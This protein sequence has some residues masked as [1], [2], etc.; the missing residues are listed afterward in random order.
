MSRIGNKSIALPKA[1]EVSVADGKVVVK[2]PKGTL[3][4]AIA[5]G[6]SFEIEDS[7]VQVRRQ[8][9]SPKF[10][11]NHGLMRALTANMVQ[12][13]STGFEK[14]LEIVG[15]GYKAEAKSNE[16]VL[17]LGFSHPIRYPFPPGITISCESPTKLTV[18]GIDK[19]RVGQ[20]A[21][22]LRGF[23]SPDSYKG[24]GVRYE[25]ER[26]RLKAGKSGQ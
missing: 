9:D 14:K 18:K 5:E 3:D 21:S 22:E 13:V 11:A 23:R 17:N 19:E 24:K 4:A 25:G 15:V 12:G 26:V 20:V 7:V 6:I 16:V 2:G 10:R 8:G 1:V